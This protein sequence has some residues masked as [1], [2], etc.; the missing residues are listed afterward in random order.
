MPTPASDNVLILMP[1]EVPPAGSEDAIKLLLIGSVDARP[2]GKFDW[3]GR[4]IKG[5]VELTDPFKG[6][7]QY[8]GLRFVVFNSVV[9]GSNPDAPPSPENPEFVTKFEWITQAMDECDIIFCNFLKN[10]KGRMPLYWFG[11]CVRSQKLVVRCPDQYIGYGLV[12]QACQ[13]FGVPL[14]PGKVGSVLAIVQAMNTISDVFNLK[15]DKN[16]L[17]E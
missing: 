11:N 4:F 16:Q 6:I 10:S 14:M 3:G 1:G 2:D 8:R 13:H 5:L 12:Q 9:P 15:Q 7:L 17:P